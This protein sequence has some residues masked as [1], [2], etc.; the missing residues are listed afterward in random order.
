MP[1]RAWLPTG[2][3]SKAILLCVHGL[4]FSSSS[5]EPFGKKLSSL[6]YATYAVDV[7]GFGSWLKKEG[8]E[9][10]D[11]DSCLQDVEQALKSL[12][13]A[14]PGE[15]VFLVGESMGGAIALSSAARYPDLVQG[16]VSAVP[17]RD[18][19]HKTSNSSK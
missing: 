2:A 4:G 7:R 1:Y 19:F 15:P 11:F 16:L 17:S 18:R 12:H 8:H 5:Y 3:R 6:G 14:Y 13:K 10:V 9:T